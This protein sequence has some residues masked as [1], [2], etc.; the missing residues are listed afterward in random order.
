MVVPA[1]S[2][3]QGEIKPNS[4]FQCMRPLGATILS[5]KEREFR[6]RL[7]WAWRPLEV[8]HV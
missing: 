8:C 3:P 2:G 7:A 6:Q 1:F 4:F 5:K